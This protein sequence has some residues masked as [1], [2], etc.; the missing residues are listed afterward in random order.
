M[1]IPIKKE[2]FMVNHSKIVAQVLNSSKTK[3]I[4][5][6]DQQDTFDIVSYVVYEEN[7]FIVHYIYTK[8]AF[9]G[10]GIIKNIFK[11]LPEVIEVTHWNK[12]VQ[13]Y[14]YKHKKLTHNPYPFYCEV[15]P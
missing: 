6:S 12:F 9:R 15:T 14:F 1:T 4:I 2:T 3:C 5:A 11:E 13:S 8:E 10:F 7:P